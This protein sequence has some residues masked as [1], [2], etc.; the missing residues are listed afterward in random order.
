MRAAGMAG[1]QVMATCDRNIIC[2]QNMTPRPI[3]LV[4]PSTNHGPTPRAAAALI[5]NAATHLQQKDY[6]TLFT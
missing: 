4:I 3:G 2:Q 5:L 1:F 6:A